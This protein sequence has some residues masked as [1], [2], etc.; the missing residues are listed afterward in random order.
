M[1]HFRI[2]CSENLLKRKSADTLMQKVYDTAEDSGLFKQ[3]DIKVRIN[4]F[5][6]YK[7]GDTK[8]DFIHVFAN[9]MEGRT[10][11]EKNMLSREIVSVLKSIFPE[12]AVIS[13]NVGDFKKEG[14]FNKFM[15]DT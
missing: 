1:P 4:S 8:K 10:A 12:V 9:I 13:M 7:L 15:L 5:K 6:Y 2:E 11:T 14:Y 3:G